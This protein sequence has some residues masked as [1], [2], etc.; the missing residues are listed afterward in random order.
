MRYTKGG[1]VAVRLMLERGG[2]AVRPMLGDVVLHYRN[3]VLH[4]NMGNSIFLFGI[5]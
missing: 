2:V 1:G 4:H 3:H 5:L